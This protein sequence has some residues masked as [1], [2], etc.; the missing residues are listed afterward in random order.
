MHEENTIEITAVSV[1]L[2]V[3]KKYVRVYVLFK[4]LAG[5]LY[6]IWSLCKWTWF[7]I[8]YKTTDTAMI[9][10]VFSS[11]KKRIF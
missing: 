4:T 1:V 8:T 5:V 2:Y 7:F 3:I 11:Q 9:S 6:Q 10:F